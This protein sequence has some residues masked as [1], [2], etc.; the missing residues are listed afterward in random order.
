[1]QLSTV[2]TVIDAEGRNSTSSSAD[3]LIETLRGVDAPN[4]IK[5]IF[6][7]SKSDS[8]VLTKL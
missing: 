5:I 3:N 4:S 6:T 1:M 2:S 8:Y 7:A